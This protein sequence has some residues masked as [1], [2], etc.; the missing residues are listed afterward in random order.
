MFFSRSQQMLICIF[1]VRAQ[2]V[3]IRMFLHARARS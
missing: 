3:L 1:F 2:H